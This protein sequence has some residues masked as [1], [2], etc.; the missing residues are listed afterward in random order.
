MGVSPKSIA[1]SP[2]TAIEMPQA[3]K[4][5]EVFDGGNALRFCVWLFDMTRS[6]SGK[7]T[8]GARENL[9]CYPSQN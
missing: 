4:C 1:A 6:V 8:Y 5:A 2:H 9:P 3:D 7:D